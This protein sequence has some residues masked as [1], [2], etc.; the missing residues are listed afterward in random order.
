MLRRHRFADG[1]VVVCANHSAVA[2][3]RP[4]TWQDFEHEL[5]PARAS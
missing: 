3:R 2:G 5:L 4:L 1:V